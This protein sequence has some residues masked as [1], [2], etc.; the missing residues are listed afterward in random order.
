MK[1]HYSWIQGV[2]KGEENNNSVIEI[3]SR[4]KLLFDSSR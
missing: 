1:K 3:D 2:K 4:R